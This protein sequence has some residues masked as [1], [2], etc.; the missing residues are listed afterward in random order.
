M[1]FDALFLSAVVEELRQKLI[2]GR[3][4]KIHQPSR[5]TVL[6]LIRGTEGREKLMIAAQEAIN[7][8]ASIAC[9]GCRYCVEGCPQQIPIPQI[10]KVRNNQLLFEMDEERAKGEYRFA[11]HGKGIASD[12]VECRQ[13]ED[14]CP[15]HLPIPDLLKECAAALE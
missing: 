12:C 2:G 8:G 9:T 1:A 6:L 7:A 11:T 13:C 14:A 15:Q 5:D 4:E 3:V 10:F